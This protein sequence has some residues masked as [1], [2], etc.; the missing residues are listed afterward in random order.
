MEKLDE[1]NCIK[2][3]IFCIAKITL[4]KRKGVP[5]DRSYFNC[6]DLVSIIYEELVYINKEISNS[7][8]K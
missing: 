5:L 2:V 1:F 3:E 6:T 8:E 4:V 7:I